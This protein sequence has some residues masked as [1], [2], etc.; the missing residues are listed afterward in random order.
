MSL[1]GCDPPKSNFMNK[2]HTKRL[3]VLYE[4]AFHINRCFNK[5]IKQRMSATR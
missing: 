5:A 3:D 1:F 2:K 4:L